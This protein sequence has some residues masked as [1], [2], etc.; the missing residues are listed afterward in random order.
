MKTR[1]PSIAIALYLL[2]NI[3]YLNVAMA[4]ESQ[5]RPTFTT[6]EGR[7]LFRGT[8]PPDKTLAVT[9][10][11]QYCGTSIQE[12]LVV[13]DSNSH[14]IQDVIVSIEGVEKSR[15][16]LPKQ[17][18]RLANHK[19]RFIPRV[20]AAYS[21]SPLQI[22]SV[23]PVLHNTHIHQNGKT[24]LNVAVPPNNRAISKR[25]ARPGILDVH[26]DAHK[27]MEAW[28]HVFTHPFFSQTDK[29]GSFKI[30]GVPPGTYQ[31]NIWHQ[32]LGAQSQTIQV[33]KT[34]QQMI[35]VE[36]KQ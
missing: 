17:A 31:L 1:L 8:I 21:G 10:D 26:C 34:D 19:C 28:V 5:A 6:V 2:S 24:F 30:S 32:Y 15:V 29:S 14:G 20:Q 25:L 7:I 35:D 36:L 12:P 23:D 4:K 18:A 3:A 13:R 11:A 22:T 27:F 16:T 9:R 33:M